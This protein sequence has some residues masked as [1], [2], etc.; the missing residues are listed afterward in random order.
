MV[1]EVII[2][3]LL[4]L[5]NAVLSAAEAAI[6]SSKEGKIENLKI[7]RFS[8]VSI[9][10][11]FKQDSKSYVPAVQVGVTIM[12]VVIGYFINGELISYLQ[13]ILD[14]VDIFR[15]FSDFLSLVVVL[16]SI[17]FL[18]LL[19]G[20]YIPEIIGKAIP[21]KTALILIYPLLVIT[22]L[23]KPFVWLLSFM[24]DSIIKL[25]G[26]K[27]DFSPVTE[28]EIKALV[29]EGVSSGVIESYEHDYWDRLLDLG[30][31]KPVQLMT[32]RRD[33]VFLDVDLSDE[34]LKDKLLEFGHTEYPVCKES[35]DDVIGVIDV[36]TLLRY[37]LE[38]RKVE[39]AEICQEV[40]FITE[41]ISIYQAL[42]DMRQYSSRVAIVV[43]EY[44]TPQGLVS[45]KHILNN[46]IGS[47]DLIEKDPTDK[48]IK[49]E[50]GSFLIDG[51]YQLSDF[52]DN[53]Q[54]QLNAF[55]EEVFLV[56]TTVGGMVFALL[57]RMPVIGDR[58]QIK[59][60][61]L[62]VLEMDGYRI[63]KLAVYTRG[64]VNLEN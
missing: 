25:L 64:S 19:F 58:V 4:I 39:L 46:L 3:L 23:I 53:F 34:E 11:D 48:I 40:P 41:N 38:G 22:V 6:G 24:R 61:T 30:D 45:A 31:K 18:L 55:D 33:V 13:S 52:F 59:E 14:R 20:R 7:G 16:L 42:E 36:K 56:N 12:A 17:T 10:L 44:G 15:T 35:F 63:H 28:E 32:H 57:D 9:L 37:F 51:R 1:T 43:D 26:L 60:L 21:E 62:Q 8:S 47:F 27:E 50:D 49:R 29:D 2:I 54:V 5:F